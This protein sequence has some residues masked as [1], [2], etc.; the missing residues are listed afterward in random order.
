MQKLCMP[1]GTPKVTRN[2]SFRRSAFFTYSLCGFNNIIITDIG[3]QK[4]IRGQ[5]SIKEL[6]SCKFHT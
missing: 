6:Q 1:R 5:R 2:K 3:I 4:F